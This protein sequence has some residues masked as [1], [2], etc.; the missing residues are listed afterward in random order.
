MSQ[1]SNDSHPRA[2]E[3]NADAVGGQQTNGAKL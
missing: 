2:N 1:E 3:G